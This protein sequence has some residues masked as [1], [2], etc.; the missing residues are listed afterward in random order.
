M[1]RFARSALKNRSRS[2]ARKNFQ[3]RMICE[4]LETRRL[5]TTF[6]VSDVRINESD[7]T[8]A[9]SIFAHSVSAPVSVD[10]STSNGTAS[11][12]SDYTANS[13]TAS[14]DSFTN[15]VIINVSLSDDSLKESGETFY[16]NLSNPSAG[17]ISD[18]VAVITILDDDAIGVTRAQDRFTA[19]GV[20]EHSGGS[21]F[22]HYVTGDGVGL[23]YSSLTYGKTI[24]DIR[25]VQPENSA[26]PSLIQAELVVNGTS[27]RTIY[28]DTT[29][30]TAGD[31]LRF[32]FDYDGSSLGSGTYDWTLKL[33][34]TIGSHQ[35]LRELSGQVDIYDRSASAIGEGW[36]ISELDRLDVST[37]WVTVLFANGSV[38]HYKRAD[39]QE[40]SG[41]GG[42][43]GGPG[44]PGSPGGGGGGGSGG[45]GLIEHSDGTFTYTTQDKSKLRFGSNGLLTSRSDLN[46][47]IS[48][49]T[50]TSGN[51]TKITRQD[52]REITFSY[53]SG[54]LASITD[55]AGRVTTLT[56][57]GSEQL[58]RITA[59]DPDGSGSLAAAE[60]DFT[61]SSTSSLLKTI[62]DAQSNLTTINYDSYDRVSSIV[63]PGNVTTSFAPQ[64]VQGLVPSGSGTSG[65]P[66]NLP[67]ADPRGSTSAP[68]SI[69]TYSKYSPLGKIIE[70]EDAL[71][72]ITLWERNDAGYVTMLVT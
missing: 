26:V 42:G 57:N 44:G 64:I 7:G 48:E 5:L 27:I 40:G 20:V 49:Y 36:E 63:A 55:W 61:Y 54:K 15:E 21:T 41:G 28:Y 30:L 14:F 45:E 34:E 10:W 71:G 39:I 47:N 31:D 18:S 29:G 56:H 70:R 50:Y 60:T 67:A 53:T 72:N 35:S 25:T 2:H 16:V 11:S 65:S 1:M 43:L 46:N 59:P 6:S 62:E 32:V 66:A 24:L 51:L 33:T 13:G 69:T 3:R 19:G 37:D 9:I 23:N 68:L 58:T 4:L 52:G 12:S 38:T 17:T 22:N 8:A